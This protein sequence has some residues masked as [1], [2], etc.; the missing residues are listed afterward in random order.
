MHL[1]E[2][3]YTRLDDPIKKYLKE[4]PYTGIKIRHLVS[5]TGDLP[6]FEIFDKAYPAACLRR[7]GLPLL[8]MAI[9]KQQERFIKKPCY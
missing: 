5:H 3:S 2:K 1:V 4:V 6:D 8:K 7:M 9:P